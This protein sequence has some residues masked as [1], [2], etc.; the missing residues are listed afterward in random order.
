LNKVLIF[1]IILFGFSSW[2][3]E[4]YFVSFKTKNTQ[5]VF[6]PYSYFDEVAI[7]N[8]KIMGL[9]LYDWYDLP[10]N[11]DYLK[12]VKSI[13]DSLGFDL[14]WFNGVTVYC[15]NLKL[16]K[17][18]SLPFVKQVV[19][20]GGAEII[21]SGSESELSK[22]LI[23]DFQVFDWQL[24]TMGGRYFQKRNLSGKG[25]R[26]GIVD[27]GFE[28]ANE[29]V[30]LNHLFENDLL[31][32][33][34]DF[35]FNKPLDYEDGPN[36]GTVVSSFVFGKLD[37]FQV[38]HAV[39]S[40]ALFAK[41]KAPFKSNASIEEAWLKAIEWM[42]QKGARIVNS[43]VGYTGDTHTHDMLTGDTCK[44]SLAANL[45]ARKGMLIVNSAGNDG[46]DVWKRIAFPGDADSLLT[47]GAIDS[48]EGVR[49]G[50]SSYGPSKDL[51]LKPN[52]TAIGDV[53]WFNNEGLRA[54]EGT[55]F[56][57]PLVAGFGACILQNTP[58]LKPMDLMDTIQKSSTLYPYFDYSHGYGVP[59]AS[60][61]FKEDTIK[62]DSASVILKTS[63][64]SLDDGYYY[65]KYK[66]HIGSQIFY[67]IAS[68]EGY[69]KEY[70]VV[71]FEDEDNSPKIYFKDLKKG[72]KIRVFH[73]G[74]FIEEEFK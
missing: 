20:L 40:E 38:G 12:T 9:P 47:V 67:Q 63:P 34:W 31:K 16:S 51:R 7:E 4:G 54:M 5:Q 48:E 21:A 33:A 23:E 61:Y 22:S 65:L 49:T 37:T 36:H 72:Q 14:R 13:A 44:M 45:A 73:R 27:V 3:N 69:I 59:R 17:I 62:G 42:H 55:S 35:A 30:Q 52:V 2:G 25:I 71:R 41:I 60:L 10:V 57:S 11:E 53:F 66:S 28:G 58:N 70:Y 15:D 32:D 6:N 1:I 43:S 39:N 29:N 8:K 24:S 56:S 50:Y 26:V 19:H 68:E 18:K 46:M 74:T 64:S